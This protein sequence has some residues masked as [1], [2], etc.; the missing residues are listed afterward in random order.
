MLETYLAVVPVDGQLNNDMVREIL[1]HKLRQ[2]RDDDILY[3]CRRHVLLDD[4]AHLSCS[5]DG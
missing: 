3:L 2:G 4:D 1:R 5:G